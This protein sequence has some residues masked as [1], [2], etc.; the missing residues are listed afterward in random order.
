MNWCSDIL[1]H[2]TT[3][4]VSR[5]LEMTYVHVY[6]AELKPIMKVYI[7]QPAFN[8]RGAPAGRANETGARYCCDKAKCQ[9]NMR[10][11]KKMSHQ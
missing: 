4:F 3:L 6:R 1:M 9:Q 2:E 11:L 8:T 7:R 5:L 10:A